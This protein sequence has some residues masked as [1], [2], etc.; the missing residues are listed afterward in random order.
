M[1]E[2]S[3]PASLSPLIT[4]AFII[5]GEMFDP[6]SCT[7][8]IGLQPSEVCVKGAHR[9]GG[10]PPVATSSWSIHFRRQ[11]L[12]SI[13]DG[14]KNVLDVIWPHRTKIQAFVTSL[15][16]KATFTSNVIVTEE[17]PLYCLSAETMRKMSALDAEFCMDIL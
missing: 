11:R 14:I 10:R 8:A 15:G 6:E 12:D 17:R 5:S 13:E 9:E 7:L 4:T 2:Q 1:M 16:L 3:Q